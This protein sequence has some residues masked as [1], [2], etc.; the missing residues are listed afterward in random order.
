MDSEFSQLS[1][2]IPTELALLD[3]LEFIHL[4]AFLLDEIPSEIGVM[5]N[6]SEWSVV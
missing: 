5:T 6:L 1:G 2:T 3:N 4:S